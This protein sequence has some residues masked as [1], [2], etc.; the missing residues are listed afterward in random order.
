MISN[1][2][3]L[4]SAHC[5]SNIENAF[6]ILGG[7]NL[8]NASETGQTRINVNVSDF[9]VHPGWNGL[10]LSDDVGLVKL[11]TPIAFNSKKA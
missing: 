10:R 8:R 4:T 5:L 1:Q 7:Q 9:V 6:V 3:I 11:P 2:W